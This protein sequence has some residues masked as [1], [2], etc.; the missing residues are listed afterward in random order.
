MG[1]AEDGLIFVSF[2]DVCLLLVLGWRTLTLTLTLTLTPNLRY[3][4][5]T[6]YDRHFC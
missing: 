4:Q 2:C 3:D 1:L 5:Q 6:L